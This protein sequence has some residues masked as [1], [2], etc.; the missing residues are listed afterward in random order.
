M[1]QVTRIFID[2]SKQFFQL[3][4][5]NEAEAVV[6]RRKLRRAQVVPY[7]RALAPTVVGLEA[8][9]ASHHLAR[10][11]SGLGHQ[12]KLVAP[13]HVSPYRKRGKSDMRDAEAGCEA[14]SRPT[15]RFVP[16]KSADDPAATML[17]AV[18]DRRIRRRT[19]LGNEIRGHAAEFG[20]IAPKGLDKIAPLLAAIAEDERLP[21]LARELFAALGGE[22]WR[23]QGQI[24]EIEAK[25]AAWTRASEA[26][27]RLAAIPGVG[28]VGAALMVT[29][30]PDPAAFKSGR[31][32]AAWIGLTPKNHSTAGK[33][34]LGV[35]TKAGDEA[36]RSVLVC[37]AMALVKRARRPG[38]GGQAR[39]PAWPW[40]ETLVAKKDPKPA[41]V[42]IANRVARIA[43]K[44][45][46]TGES[47]DARRA[48][49]QHTN[50]P[51]ANI[52]A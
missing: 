46:L 16:V 31:D 22:F 52:A 30:T 8:C 44:M 26:S 11:L 15:M 4:G 23:L 20:L 43:W 7:F 47:Y 18:R 2:T 35:I 39:A 45:M 21:L 12:P 13:Q 50:K 10:T 40:L 28:P 34:R 49:T 24:R 3:H 29:K 9:G 51:Q 17:L 1:E 32:Y 25:L 36:L 37:G 27:S 14:M 41:A 6:V 42:A 5:V 19:A 33:E 38:P 48:W